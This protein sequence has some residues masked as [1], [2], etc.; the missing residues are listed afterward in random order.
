MMQR[1]DWSSHI[2]MMGMEKDTAAWKKILCQ[3]P[4]EKAKIHLPYDTA[5]RFLGNYPRELKHFYTKAHT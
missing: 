2:L 3:F 1:M 4:E 5:A